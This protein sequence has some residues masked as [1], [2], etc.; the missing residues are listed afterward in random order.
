[1]ICQNPR[2]NL[3]CLET[4]A[5]ISLRWCISLLVSDQCKVR[6][7]GWPSC[8]CVHQLRFVPRLVA[9]KYIVNTSKGTNASK[10]TNGHKWSQMKALCFLQLNYFVAMHANMKAAE[11][12][13]DPTTPQNQQQ[14]QQQVPPWLLSVH[15]LT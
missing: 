15:F 8:V 9:S 10:G 4:F 3:K 11:V 6:L 12:K 5:C 2:L 1:M 7:Q 14:I 13:L